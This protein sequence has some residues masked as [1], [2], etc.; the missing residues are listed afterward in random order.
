[1]TDSENESQSELEANARSEWQSE[2]A[3]N[4][5]SY[6]FDSS[7]SS[8]FGTLQFAEQVQELKRISTMVSVIIAFQVQSM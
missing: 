2:T 3:K 5:E 4:S 6:G 7:A 8:D 1:M